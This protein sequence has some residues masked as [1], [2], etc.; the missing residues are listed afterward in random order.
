L[1]LVCRTVDHAS[2][3][4]RAYANSAIAYQAKLRDRDIDLSGVKAWIRERLNEGTKDFYGDPI[5]KFGPRR[6]ISLIPLYRQYYNVVDLMGSDVE[7]NVPFQCIVKVRDHI[8]NN[9]VIELP[10]RNDDGRL[11]SNWWTVN[12]TQIQ[13]LERRY[14]RVAY[15]SPTREP[16]EEFTRNTNI[17]VN[18]N[19]RVNATVIHP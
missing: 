10:L 16:V 15:L 7:L 8:P 2:M 3:S 11:V 14:S 13:H 19:V 1:F 18:S 9:S 17:V 5:I 6:P 12:S 4:L